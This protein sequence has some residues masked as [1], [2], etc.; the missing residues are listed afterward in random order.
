MLGR[1]TFTQEEYTAAQTAVDAQLEAIRS[2][3][4]AD[5]ALCN[6][7]LLALDRRFVHRVRMVTGKETNP[8]NEVELL[9]E[10][11]MDH[12]AVLTTNTVIKY[13]PS[14]AVLGIEP[15]QQIAL[16]DQQFEQLA[17]AFFEELRARFL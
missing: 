4:Q 14:A 17:R 3:G 12:D 5:P 2:R 8:L 6:A 10:S 9:V 7:L 15:G 1:K 13:D 11:L 16:D